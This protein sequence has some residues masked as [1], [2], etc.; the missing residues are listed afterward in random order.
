MIDK[1]VIK[2]NVGLL[3]KYVREEMKTQGMFGIKIEKCHEVCLSSF[4]R[5]SI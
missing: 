2:W 4:I 3:Q 5:K 1:T